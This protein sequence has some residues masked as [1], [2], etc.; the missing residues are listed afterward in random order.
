MGVAVRTRKAASRQ[1]GVSM[2]EVLIA[3]VMFLGITLATVPMFTRSMESNSSGNDST[4][5]AN[6]ARARV[7]QLMQLPF[8]HIDL[9]IEAG[10]EKTTEEYL[11]SEDET[12]KPL[13][14]AADDS[15]QWFRTSVVRQYGV[16]ALDD[17]TIQTAEALAAGTDPG[18]VHLKEIQVQ[19][20]QAGG[21]FSSSAKTV[22]L[23]LFKSQ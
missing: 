6:F 12:W 17:G 3:A 16:S 13:P 23:R 18:L 11:S 15:A 21:L 20:D 7:E 19:V 5:V 4:N 1:A 10:S 8:N 22:T 9:T 14:V 2:V